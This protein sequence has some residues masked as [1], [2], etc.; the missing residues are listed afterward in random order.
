MNI[1]FPQNKKSN[2]FRRFHGGCFSLFC[3]TQPPFQMSLSVSPFIIGFAWQGL[4]SERGTHT[5]THSYSLSHTQTHTHTHVVPIASRCL[6]SLR[7]SKG[8][9]KSSGHQNCSAATF[10]IILHFFLENETKT[11]ENK[12]PNMFS[13]YLQLER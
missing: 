7:R 10:F 3:R 11:F 2:L 1:F 5:H 9:E 13:S 8:G 12:I 4:I 6:A